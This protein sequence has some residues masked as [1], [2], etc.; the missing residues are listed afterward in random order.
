MA[1]VNETLLR[2]QLLDRRQRLERALA[3]APGE[4]ELSSLLASVDAALAR[5]DD[6]SYGLCRTCHDPVEPERLLADPLLEF[7]LDHLSAA[8]QRALEQDLDR[9]ARIQRGLLPDA[10]LVVPGWQVA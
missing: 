1:S 10:H 7:C 2:P 5:L 9:A 6:G 3:V 4:A 8:E